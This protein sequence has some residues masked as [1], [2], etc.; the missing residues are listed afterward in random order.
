MR[1]SALAWWLGGAVAVATAAGVALG[2]KRGRARASSP[3]PGAESSDPRAHAVGVLNID[4]ATVQLAPGLVLNVPQAL[5]PKAPGYRLVDAVAM[6]DRVLSW[7]ELGQGNFSDA[8]RAALAG[9]RLELESWAGLGGPGLTERE[10]VR[11]IIYSVIVPLLSNEY[12]AELGPRWLMPWFYPHKDD[13]LYQA[14][15]GGVA[16]WIGMYVLAPE[17]GWVLAPERRQVISGWA[18]P[19]PAPGWDWHGYADAYGWELGSVQDR[20]LALIQIYWRMMRYLVDTCDA[21]PKYETE[22]GNVCDLRAAAVSA[23]DDVSAAEA[24]Q[25]NTMEALAAGNLRRVELLTGATASTFMLGAEVQVHFGWKQV[26]AVIVAL[27]GSVV[28]T[29]AVGAALGATLAVA[30]SV[31]AAAVNAAVA[32]GDAIAKGGNVAAAMQSAIGT[33]VT[34]Y[35]QQQ[36]KL[37]VPADLYK[38]ANLVGKYGK[39]SL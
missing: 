30:L 27:V 38:A 17:T 9:W 16:A 1:E 31:S 23:I 2:V 11:G 10:R 15:L 24:T 6:A 25:G 8:E 32:I 5:K 35:L 20:K 12:G 36:A 34:D 18:H 21:S 4:K 19:L 14:Q 33:G 22:A 26:V 37:L 28:G 29:P 39:I 7:A 3:T 13:P